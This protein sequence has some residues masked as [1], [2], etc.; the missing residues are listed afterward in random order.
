[1]PQALST[2]DQVEATADELTAGADAIHQ[3]L[4]KE[5]AQRRGV[6]PTDEEQAAYRALFEEE[7]ALRERANGMYAD[8]AAMV[9]ATFAV[10]QEHVSELTRQAAEKIRTITRIGDAVGVAAALG[11]FAGAILTGAPVG[12]ANAFDVLRRT[13]L[14]ARA[15][16]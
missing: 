8:A 10:P 14:A 5:L 2:P 9:V 15:H 12:I 1:M 3:R 13:V 7:V 16:G 6:P 11:G 4:V